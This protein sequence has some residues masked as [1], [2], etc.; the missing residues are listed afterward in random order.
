MEY[1]EYWNHV[2][3]VNDGDRMEYYHVLY[4][5]D[6]GEAT[7]EGYYLNIE[8][9]LDA[10]TDAGIKAGVIYEGEHIDSYDTAITYGDTLEE[11]HTLI[12]EDD[13]A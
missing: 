9:F 7:F 5:T 10:A 12:A 1:F 8:E 6:Y 2:P 11:V 4:D 3:S 13:A